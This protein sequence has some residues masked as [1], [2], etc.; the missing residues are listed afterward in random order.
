MR[1]PDAR[2]AAHFS[3]LPEEWKIVPLLYATKY[4]TGFTPPSGNDKYYG[5]D[6]PWVNISDLDGRRVLSDTQ[7][8]LSTDA[9]EHFPEKHP[10]PKGS[11]LFSFKLSLGNVAIAGRDLFTNEAIAAFIPNKEL[12]IDYAYYCFPVFLPLYS[13]T[14]IYGA[15]LLGASRFERTKIPLPPVETQRRIADYLDR[16]TAEIDAAV[17]DLNKYMELLRTRRRKLLIR[18][19]NDPKYNP[20]NQR[21]KFLAVSEDHRRVPIKSSDRADMR[22]DYPYYGASGIIDYVN[23]YIWD[24][25]K[26]LL[27]SEDGANLQMRNHPIAFVASGQYWVNNHAHVLKCQGNTH[28]EL[29]ALAI[30]I[31]SIAHLITGSAQPKLTATA[32]GEIEFPFPMTSSG[33][34]QL[35][36]D[37]QSELGETDTIVKES[38]KLRDLLLKRRSVLI[39]EVVTG[40]KQV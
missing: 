21:L 3:A 33:Q 5:G 25:E 28:P 30:E 18:A 16:E 11:L 10:A 20:V 9:I 38:T 35:L 13:Q 12:S 22:G 31:T 15:E 26:R 24:N 27:L 2:K 8:S 6:Y 32:M 37:L 39:T 17:A 29:V 7:R 4:T 34:N 40:R 14:N 19:F 36:A 1:E 23:D